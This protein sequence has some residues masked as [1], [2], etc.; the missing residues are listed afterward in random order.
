[1]RI[2]IGLKFCDAAKNNVK[3]DNVKLYIKNHQI[4]LFLINILILVKM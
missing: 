2:Y 3:Q 1:M 4:P